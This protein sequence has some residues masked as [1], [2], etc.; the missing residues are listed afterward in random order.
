MTLSSYGGAND[1]SQDSITNVVMNGGSGNGATSRLVPI[2]LGLGKERDRI[3]DAEAAF[4]VS[5]TSFYPILFVRDGVFMF[6]L[7]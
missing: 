7:C 4:V 1:E 5:A 2:L 3:I 6:E